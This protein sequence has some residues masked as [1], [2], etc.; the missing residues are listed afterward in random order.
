MPTARESVRCQ[1]IDKIKNLL[2]GGPIPVC[3][4]QHSD[5]TNACLCRVVL[6]IASHSY[7]HHYGA[8]DIAAKENR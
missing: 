4:K 3:T 5:F 7:R 1:E 8:G 2:I 6:L